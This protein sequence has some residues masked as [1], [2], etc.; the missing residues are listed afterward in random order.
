MKK[1]ILA[2]LAIFGAYKLF[3]YLSKQGSGKEILGKFKKLLSEGNISGK[4]VEVVIEDPTTGAEGVVSPLGEDIA[5]DG[6]DNTAARISNFMENSQSKV[7]N[8]KVVDASGNVIDQ[9]VIDLLGNNTGSG[10]KV[11]GT[12][13]YDGL[14]NLIGTVGVGKECPVNT[15]KSHGGWI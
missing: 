12:Y 2:A 14:G 8:I 7:F 6:G 9:G 11:Y 13:C 15:A 3:Q 1:L 4:D 10:Q 5:G